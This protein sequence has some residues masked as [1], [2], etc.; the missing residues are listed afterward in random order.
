MKWQ[1]RLFEN[2]Y[3]FLDLKEEAEGYLNYLTE[4]NIDFADY[5][6]NFA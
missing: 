6:K 4:F 2:D 5:L 3:D 1:R